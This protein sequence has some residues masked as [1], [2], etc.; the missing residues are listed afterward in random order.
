MPLSIFREVAP[1][2]LVD[3]GVERVPE[4]DPVEDCVVVTF[5]A[6][7]PNCAPASKAAALKAVKESLGSSPPPGLTGLTAKTIP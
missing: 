2:E 1:F 6:G 3:V 7:A 4:T 5:L